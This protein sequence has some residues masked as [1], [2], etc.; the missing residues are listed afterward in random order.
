MQKSVSDSVVSPSLHVQS[1]ATPLFRAAEEGHTEMAQLLLGNGSS[2]AEQDI[3][4]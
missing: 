4:G 3:V 2:V 1:G